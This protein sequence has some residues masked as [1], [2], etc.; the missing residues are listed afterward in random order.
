MSEQ[1]PNESWIQ[2]KM[3]PRALAM[4][5]VLWSGPRKRSFAAFKD[6]ADSVVRKLRNA[7]F[8]AAAADAQD[9]DA[10][11]APASHDAAI[12]SAAVGCGGRNGSGSVD[13]VCGGVRDIA[14]RAR[15]MRLCD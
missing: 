5:E 2:W 4:S 13:V 1:V 7:G 15:D 11:F 12:A 10:T 6:D 9:V 14:G 3:W 8:N